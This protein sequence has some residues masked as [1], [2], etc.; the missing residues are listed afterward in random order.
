MSLNLITR[1]TLTSR[2]MMLHRSCCLICTVTYLLTAA[3]PENTR[4]VEAETV[5]MFSSSPCYNL[6]RSAEPW[7][8]E[9]SATVLVPRTETVCTLH[10]KERA[11]SNSALKREFC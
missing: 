6:H 9:V 4:H 5:I 8:R 11:R 7:P 2:L 3:G 10:T 1:S